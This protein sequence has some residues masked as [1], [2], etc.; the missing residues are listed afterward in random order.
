MKMKDL[1]NEIIWDMTWNTSQRT[2][3]NKCK[4]V[5]LCKLIE[6]QL[7]IIHIFTVQ[8]QIENKIII[9]NNKKKIKPLNYY[10]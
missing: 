2:V 1:K 10:I 8:W 9:M 4:L 7:N 3:I 6:I 5:Y